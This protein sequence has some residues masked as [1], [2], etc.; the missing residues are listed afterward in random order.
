MKKGSISKGNIFSVVFVLAVCVCA[1]LAC[2]SLAGAVAVDVGWYENFTTFKPV[3]SQSPK[4]T[5]VALENATQVVT[6]RVDMGEYGSAGPEYEVLVQDENGAE[7]G[8]MTVPSDHVAFDTTTNMTTLKTVPLY[9]YDE[10]N[11]PKVGDT[12]QV[13]V[14]GVLIAEEK[15]Y[16][17]ESADPVKVT[18]KSNSGQEGVDLSKGTISFVSNETVIYTGKPITPE[19]IVLVDD[20]K[21]TR[22][23]DYTMS[24]ENNTNVGTAR[25]IATGISPNTGVL[26]TTFVIHPRAITEAELVLANTTVTYT[27][28]PITPEETLTVNGVQ[29]KRDED[30]TMSYENNTNVGTA[31][32]IATGKGNYTGTASKTFTIKEAEQKGVDLSKGTISFVSNET[33]IY[34]GKPITPEE[35]VLVDDKTL[36][37]DRDYTMS[38]GNNLNVG[39][40]KAIATGVSPNT[41]ELNTTFVIHPRDISEAELVLANT[42][43]TYTGSPITPEE[44]LTVNGVQLKRDEDYTM[45]YEN[46]TNVGTA[47]AIATGKGNYTGTASKTFTITE[48]EQ[49]AIDL[50][51][52][53]ITLKKTRY[54]YNGKAKKPGVTVVLDG[55]TLQKDVDYTVTYENNVNAGKA[56]VT[57]TGKGA[58]KGSAKKKFTILKAANTIRVAPLSVTARHEK[59]MTFQEKATVKGGAKVTFKLASVP[60]E[61]KKYISVSSTGKITV[62]KGIPKGVCKIKIRVTA[63]ATKNF[64]KTVKTVTVRIKVK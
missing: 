39:T 55:K 47:K 56:G 12:V 10:D 49:E 46:N 5:I 22:D 40:A 35:I 31:K 6:M 15:E 52:A 50:S 25:A 38:Y 54:E 8:I 53:T 26:N 7:I 20:K 63:K 23:Q 29:L 17:C 61:V 9:Y 62:K 33:V 37:R 41:G 3:I 30:Y 19:E 48:A 21:L 18:I 27:G 24:Y 4:P 32:A 2:M 43:V 58:Y 34:T 13:T 57:V 42:T 1:V 16:P 45:S 11:P 36:T 28:S 44:T 59:T 60:K 14:F 64:K 51:Q